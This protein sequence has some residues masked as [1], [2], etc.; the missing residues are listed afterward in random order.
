[1]PKLVLLL[2]RRRIDADNF[3][4]AH[5]LDSGFAFRQNCCWLKM[6]QTIQRYEKSRILTEYGSGRYISNHMQFKRVSLQLKL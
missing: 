3:Q 4:K 1:M 6:I 2:L 5:S